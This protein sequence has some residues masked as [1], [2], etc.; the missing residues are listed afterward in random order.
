MDF[1]TCLKPHIVLQKHDR[2]KKE[3]AHEN[4]LECCSNDLS[5]PMV[6]YY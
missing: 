6:S 2:S 1:L 5:T 4:N 3:F